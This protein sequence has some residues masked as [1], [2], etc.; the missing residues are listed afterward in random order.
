MQNPCKQLRA[1]ASRG[2]DM[3]VD[4]WAAPRQGLRT[5]AEIANAATAY[6]DSACYDRLLP[7]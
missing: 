1:L 6:R 5:S 2:A 4:P 3:A 7:A